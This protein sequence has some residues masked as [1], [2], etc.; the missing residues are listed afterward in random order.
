MH[1]MMST[2]PRVGARCYPPF[3]WITKEMMSQGPQVV[4]LEYRE[5]DEKEGSPIIPYLTT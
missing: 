2:C 5:E 4:D 3:L 1:S